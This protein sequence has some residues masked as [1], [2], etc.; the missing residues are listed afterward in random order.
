[1]ALLL[2]ISTAMHV[3]EIYFKS[4]LYLKNYFV[5]ILSIKFLR[6]LNCGIIIVFFAVIDLKSLVM[7]KNLNVLICVLFIFLLNSCKK[8][9]ESGSSTSNNI[10]VA[11]PFL[12]AA[13]TK[14]VDANNNPVLL[15]G[16]AFG[17]WVWTDAIAYDHHNEQDFVRV[18]NMGMNAIRFYLNYKY[19]END[20][21]PYQYKQ[22]GWDYLNQNIGWAK[23]NGVYLILNMHVPQGGYQSQGGGDALWTNVEN[24]NRLTALWKTIANKYKDEKQI[25]GYGLV[26]EIV[27]TTSLSQWQQLAQRLTDS[28]RVV[29]KNHILFIEK[30]IYVKGQNTENA[31]YNFPVIN[32]NN[33]VY[34]FH[35]YEP[36][37]YTH[38]LFS[39]SG[40]PD[41]GKYPD[42]NNIQFTNADWHTAIFNNPSAPTGNS[43]WQRFE[44]QKYKITD[45]LIKIGIPA[46]VAANVTGRVYFDSV[47]ILE[48]DPAGNFTQT[49][50]ALNLNSLDNWGYWSNNGTG[51]KGLSTTTG[52]G[53][54][55]SFYIESATGDC[56]LSNYQKGFI[57]KQ[58]YYYQIN[59]WMKGENVAATS[60]C[61][62]RIDFLKTNDPIYKRDKAYMEFAI[63]KYANWGQAKNVPVY[64]GE[65]GAGNPCFQN[66]KGGLQF[67]T[68]V[69]DITK[70]SNI[71][72]T[73]HAYHESSFG[74]YYG[75]SGL[76][77]PA[78]ANQP[79]IDLFTQKL[80]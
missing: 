58:N 21:T 45:P 54:N 63:N 23:A 1:L 28:I 31:D 55:S 3:Q 12:L 42:E 57:A 69:I 80:R 14:I 8:K 56:N 15:R 71:H 50:A 52:V 53:D 22:E 43:N 6:K 7:K 59:G 60:A 64:M 79:L 16:V 46:L 33:K 9:V 37:Y 66:G 24:Q 29:D 74:I 40:L 4:L 19:F 78:L 77:N 34:E 76:P 73:Y 68:D 49:I 11:S 35:T 67:V 65:F 38:Q 17:N 75:D 62:I 20:A 44:G 25:V 41:G 61:K 2:V 27:P 32:D 36:Y 39:W 10:K 26:N 72:F 13:G 48:F 70:A 5:Y 51:T 47:S 18:K 30:P